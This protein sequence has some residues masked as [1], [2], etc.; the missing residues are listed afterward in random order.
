[1]VNNYTTLV[2]A[3]DIAKFN[4]TLNIITNAIK[5][6]QKHIN[7]ISINELI[8]QIEN[9]I[10]ELTT[11][12]PIRSKRGAINLIGNFL[13]W[14]G[15]VMDADDKQKIEKNFKTTQGNLKLLRRTS[16]YQIKINEKF[17]KEINFI[18]DKINIQNNI[19]TKKFEEIKIKKIVDDLSYLKLE[20]EIKENLNYLLN[21]LEKYETI[22]LTSK[23]GFLNKNILDTQ[24]IHNYIN[25]ETLQNIQVSIASHASELFVFVQIPNFSENKY[26]KTI[27][28]PMPN[29]NNL[30]LHN[31]INTVVTCKNEVYEFTNTNKIKNLKPTNDKCISTIL[32]KNPTECKM[33]T[34]TK[35]E[36]IEIELDII[37]TKNL[38]ETKVDHNCN[39]HELTISGNTVIKFKNCKVTILNKT[40]SNIETRETLVLPNI[41]KN[42]SYKDV[43]HLTLENLHKI[44]IENLHRIHFAKQETE[45]TKKISFTIDIFI[46]ISLLLIAFYFI[47]KYWKSKKISQE[48]NPQDGRVICS[49]PVESRDSIF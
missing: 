26:F 7:F 14:I 16:N 47:F 34:N 40:C 37:I 13:N 6:N 35:P 36:I 44:Q 28:V 39:N 2:H 5:E 4:N 11:H 9:K 3:I 32:T 19:I 30:E 46:I 25:V 1:M 22:V 27:I 31:S 23:S 8:Q 33:I 42:I 12:S 48:S 10:F 24:E 15:G 43:T 20:I 21:I 41:I 45:T 17:E 29:K 18:I 49:T 38:N